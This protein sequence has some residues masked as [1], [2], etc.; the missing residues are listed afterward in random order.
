MFSF[1]FYAS[2]HLLT[3]LVHLAIAVLIPSIGSCFAETGTVWWFLAGLGDCGSDS[4]HL[5]ALT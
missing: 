3:V 4:L 1:Y 2:H 5:V